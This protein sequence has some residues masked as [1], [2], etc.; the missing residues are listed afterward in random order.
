MPNKYLCI[1]SDYYNFIIEY[2][3]SLNKHDSE[4]KIILLDNNNIIQHIYNKIDIFIFVNELPEN[5]LEVKNSNIFVL[6]IEQLTRTKFE[7]N[8][9]N[10]IKKGINL[11]DY[12]IENI[13]HMKTS[14][15]HLP[16]QYNEEEIDKLKNY[17]KTNK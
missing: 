5:L 15:Y 1:P 14:M 13:K 12:S 17:N 4:L 7:N 8:V 11:I 10:L 3:N 16:Y 6:N 9:T 2:I